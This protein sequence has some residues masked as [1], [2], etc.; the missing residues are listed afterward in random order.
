MLWS[1]LLEPLSLYLLILDM[2]CVCL[3]SFNFS[4]SLISFSSDLSGFY[5]FIR[6][7]PFY[8]WSS[9]LLQIQ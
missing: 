7:C 6:F 2:M 3:F 9:A 1:C 8:C 4:E 5:E